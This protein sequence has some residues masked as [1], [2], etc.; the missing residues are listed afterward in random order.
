MNLSINITISDLC[1]SLGFDPLNPTTFFNPF[2]RMLYSRP[3]D[4]TRVW[5]HFLQNAAYE[6]YWRPIYRKRRETI[7]RLWEQHRV[8]FSKLS[9]ANQKLVASLINDERFFSYDDKSC[10][11]FSKRVLMFIMEKVDGKD[12]AS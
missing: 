12:G 10:A 1:A 11:D 5:K 4:W 8:N 3:V 7:N 2:K 6:F 9:Q